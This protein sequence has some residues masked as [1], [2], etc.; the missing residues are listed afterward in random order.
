MLILVKE[1]LE[2]LGHG[3]NLLR[4]FILVVFFFPSK[5]FF[6]KA[7]L[8]RNTKMEFYFRILLQSSCR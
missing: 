8:T 5:T 4:G 7:R 6:I 2:C 1:G 3:R